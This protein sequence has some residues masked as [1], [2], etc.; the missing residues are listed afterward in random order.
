MRTQHPVVSL[1]LVIA[2]SMSVSGCGRSSGPD[3]TITGVSGDAQT[4]PMSG[5]LPLPLSFVVVTGTGDPVRGAAVTWSATPAGAAT[6]APATSTTN[7]S[8]AASTV[9]TLGT[10]AGDIELRATVGSVGFV[11]FTANAVPP[12]EFV[13]P[14][15]LGTTKHAALAATDCNRNGYYYDFYGPVTAS[16]QQGWTVTMSAAFNTWIDVLRAPDDAF[17]SNGSGATTST[18]HMIVAPGEYT[19]GVNSFAQGVTGPY[20]FSSV[21]RPQTLSGC[22][23]VFITRGVTIT[24][25]VVAGECPDSSAAGVFYGE[26]ASM[27]VAAGEVVTAT[28]RSSAFDPVL[29]VTKLINDEFVVVASNND[30]A[31]GHTTAFVEYVAPENTLVVLYARPSAQRAT[32]AYTLSVEASLATPL[33]LSLRRN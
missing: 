27:F 4:G 29:V 5:Q 14:Y 30:S 15:A 2:L 18:V 3:R 19:F 24:D 6:F 16:S 13:H 20:T 28:L 32:G 26:K 22:A 9:V 7:S 17:A 12:C 23:P 11:T 33:P 25:Q 10:H 1:C 31:S 8:G 21:T